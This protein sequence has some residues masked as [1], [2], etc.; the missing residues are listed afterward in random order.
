MSDLTGAAADPKS[1]GVITGRRPLSLRIGFALFLLGL[2]C[3]I[4][5]VLPFFW[6]EGNRPLWLNLGCMLAP[7]GF[8]IAVTAVLRA[9]R[10]D[11]RAALSRVQ[12]RNK[13]RNPDRSRAAGGGSAG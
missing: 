9:G 12:D 10:A 13:N 2:G 5:T 8:V 1:R 4:A 7:L 3:L 6:G 11:Q